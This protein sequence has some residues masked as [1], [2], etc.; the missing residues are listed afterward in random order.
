VAPTTRTGGQQRV[1]QAFAG[2]AGAGRLVVRARRDVVVDQRAGR[3]AVQAQLGDAEASRE[4]GEGGDGRQHRLGVR[5]MELEALRD[6]GEGEVAL[7]IVG[8]DV[9]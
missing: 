2:V 6:L 3:R 5:Q 9:H 7:A 8:D 4:R 1:G